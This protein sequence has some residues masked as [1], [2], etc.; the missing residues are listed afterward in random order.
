M[1]GEKDIHYPMINTRIKRYINIFIHMKKILSLIVLNLFAVV[2]LLAQSEGTELFERGYQNA[3]TSKDA[4]KWA[5]PSSDATIGTEYVEGYGLHTGPYDHKT[6][7]RIA[8]VASDTVCTVDP[9]RGLLTVDAQWVSYG[10]LGRAWYDDETTKSLLN[11]A[12]FRIGNVYLMQNAQS[13]SLAYSTDGLNTYN[14]FEIEGMTGK[15]NPWGGRDT[16]IVNIPFINIKM[17]ID[18]PHNKLISMQLSNANDPEGTVLYEVTDVDIKGQD[19]SSLVLESG[20]H[21]TKSISGSP[22][23]YLK[24][25]KIV[26][27]PQEGEK[28]TYSVNYKFDGVQLNE[29]EQ[30][31]GFVGDTVN[32]PE[33]FWI[34][35]SEGNKTKYFVKDAHDVKIEKNSSDGVEVFTFDVRKAETY[36]CKVTSDFGKVLAEQTVIEGEEAPMVYWNKFVKND[37]DGCWYETQEPY[38]IQSSNTENMNYEVVYTKSD[39]TYFYDTADMFIKS[40][41]TGVT[42]PKMEGTR[43]SGGSSQR[44]LL[45]DPTWYA[46]E[47]ISDGGIFEVSVPWING[48][49]T[50]SYV[51]I[52]TYTDSINLDTLVYN[53]GKIDE[54][55]YTENSQAG[56]TADARSNGTAVIEGFEV[57]L[58]SG[59]LLQYFGSE[60]SHA[61]LD[62]VT[63][64]WLDYLKATVEMQDNMADVRTQQK[65]NMATPLRGFV[66]DKN[67]I[68]SKNDDITAYYLK[69][70]KVSEQG[71][72]KVL[73]AEFDT[74]DGAVPVGTVCVLAAEAGTTLRVP[75]VNHSEFSYTPN[76]E[77]VGTTEWTKQLAVTANGAGAEASS[78]KAYC[79]EVVDGTV[80]F[81]EVADPTAVP[82]GVVYYT[83]PDKILEDNSIVSA[84][85]L[86]SFAGGDPVSV[87][88][89][90]TVNYAEQVAPASYNVLGQRVDA[91]AKGLVICGGKKFVNK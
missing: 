18:M 82:D 28:A 68:F 54:A 52:D 1:Y 27:T 16:S 48:N 45:Y 57:P 13:A 87:T 10:S 58:N 89:I 55:Y 22:N 14:I 71:N 86:V 64:K 63:L 81:T 49:N 40:S 24:A 25:L 17:Q 47:L 36:T 77:T 2:P 35:D 8:A 62:Y 23:E 7:I 73:V 9:S 65:S 39:I 51:E 42:P 5:Q 19:W 85:V 20:F 26:E 56:L 41:H 4:A 33:S 15:A 83:V 75:Y 90:R 46:E 76:T 43:F 11:C 12:Y 44:H 53:V 21:K 30:L 84:D 34:T 72:D 91:S 79:L 37:E 3:W 50:E 80:K 31:Q 6:N 32:I 70:V 78:A 38:G 67:Y 69:D 74:I 59:I 60:N 61:S 88:G 66:C 29:T